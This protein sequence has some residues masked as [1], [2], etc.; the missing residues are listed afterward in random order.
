MT[1]ILAIEPD[2]KRGVT[3]RT[4]VRQRLKAEITLATSTDAAIARMAEKPPTLILVSSVIAPDEDL[5][6]AAHL[7]QEPALRHVPVLTVPFL[8][9]ASIGAA[10]DRQGLLSRLVRRRPPSPAYDF[11][12]VVARIEDAIELARKEA[13]L[14][15]FGYLRPLLIDPDS[16]PQ[17][18][19]APHDVVHVVASG[20]DAYCGPRS[21]RSR[22]PRLTGGELPWLF[23]IK[24]TWGP[25][26]QL[27][28]ISRSGLL[29]ETGIRLT[30]GA[31]TAFEIVGPATDL[32]V[33]ARVIRTQVSA[34]DTIG[35]KYLAAA[36]FEQSFDSLLPADDHL[37]SPEP[38]AV[39]AELTTRVRD[40]A[41]RGAHAV[42][43]RAEF[44]A[45]IQELV[46]GCEVRLRE[47]PMAENDGRDA[48][49]FTVPGNNHQRAVLQVTFEPGRQPEPEEF[50][51]LKAAS[52]AASDVLE[53]TEP[54]RHKSLSTT[55]APASAPGGVPPEAPG[56]HQYADDVRPRDD[57]SCPS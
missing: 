47:A 42:E 4:L 7:R 11:G 22:A 24:L 6:L 10:V 49:Y 52:L 31:S 26:L 2:P 43:L 14:E 38:A 27:V 36:A 15:A 41:A 16:S 45:A 53:F 32:I 34:V 57:K 46:T 29:V 40:A 5:R 55:Q 12:A 28:N 25:E 35:V 1:R 37:E 48:V 9:D 19:D 21:K 23:S 54:A 56:S 3:L 33:R 44:E 13:A 50:E 8:L 39:L 30:P 20:L 18:V 17:A 51:A